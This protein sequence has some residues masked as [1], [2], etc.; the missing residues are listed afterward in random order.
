[1]MTVVCPTMF[2]YARD[3]SKEV[4]DGRAKRLPTKR[5]FFFASIRRL[6]RFT[7]VASLGRGFS[8]ERTGEPRLQRPRPFLSRRDASA[9]GRDHSGER[10]G[11]VGPRVQHGER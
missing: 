7:P 5:S 4:S 11:N 1:M 6:K 10:A 2:S 9:R 8:R 3:T